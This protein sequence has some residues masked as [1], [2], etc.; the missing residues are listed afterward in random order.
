MTK[1]KRNE[2]TWR[3]ITQ[4]CINQESNLRF[5]MKNK[6]LIDHSLNKTEKH[7]SKIARAEVLLNR[8]ELDKREMLNEIVNDFP[9]V[10][11]QRRLFEECEQ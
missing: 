7:E 2:E 10:R 9:Y 3:R 6:F 8:H 11:K 4:K 5:R 1:L